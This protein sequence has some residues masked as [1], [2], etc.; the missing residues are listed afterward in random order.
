[1]P[2]RRAAK[3]HLLP[4]S[5]SSSSPSSPSGPVGAAVVQQLSWALQLAGKAWPK[6]GP[7][8]NLVI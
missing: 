3:R 4:A 8:Q 2:G 5:S 7:E 1:M 6:N